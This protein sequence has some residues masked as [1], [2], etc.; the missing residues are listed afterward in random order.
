M[1]LI[2]KI[3][4]SLFVTLSLSTFNSA[5]GMHYIKQSINS[6]NSYFSNDMISEFMNALDKQKTEE[7][8]EWVNKIYACKN[9]TDCQKVRT[10][11]HDT[12]VNFIKSEAITDQYLTIR[13]VAHHLLDL[14]QEFFNTLYS[15]IVSNSTFFLACDPYSIVKIAVQCNDQQFI[16]LLQLILPQEAPNKMYS[17]LRMFGD[18]ILKRTNCHSSLLPILEKHFC[19]LSYYHQNW[20]TPLS[21]LLG[22]EKVIALTLD[23]INDV[24]NNL[25]IM[26]ITEGIPNAHK[27]LPALM[28]SNKSLE[29]I[30]RIVVSPNLWD[31]KTKT[32]PTFVHINRTLLKRMQSEEMVTD[33]RNPALRNL[34]LQCMD[35]EITLNDQGF[36][37][38]VHGQRRELYFPEKLYT[39]LWGIRKKQ[40][41]NNFLFA[42]VKDVVTSEQDKNYEKIIRNFLRTQGTNSPETRRYVLFMNY[43]F[44]GNLDNSGSCTADYIK[45]NA[46]STL[47][48]TIKLSAKDPFTKLGYEWAYNKYKTEIEKLAADY[49]SVENYGNLLLFAIPK[50]KINKYVYLARTGGPRVSLKIDGKEV[51]DTQTILETFIN[52]PYN[53][54]D[55]NKREFC[56]I[57]TQNKGGLDPAT[58]IQVHPILSGDPEKLQ[59]LKQREDA[60]FAKI[61]IDIEEYEKQQQSV[62]RMRRIINHLVPN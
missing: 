35:K 59:L 62:G 58:G 32:S 40:P 5:M 57:M 38:F 8:I 51:F 1:K 60:L 53:I 55:T 24:S 45:S 3:A 25:I 34:F 39:H 14:D 61:R 22:T 21:T 28:V 4:F 41:V 12:I 49:C 13:S 56:L 50:E 48:N 15:T 2:H 52:Q 6:V 19:L 54:A 7:A 27:I 33:F 46:N 43:A 26:L 11:I 31:I 44:F 20:F 23:N 9:Q 18:T 37:T 10:R 17:P 36:Y 29:D 30:R 16:E 42:H 47:G